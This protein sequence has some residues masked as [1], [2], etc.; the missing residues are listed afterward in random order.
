MEVGQ[1]AR[2]VENGAEA[3]GY[4]TAIA[5]D[6]VSAILS[7]VIAL[8]TLFTLRDGLRG[9]QSRNAVT[10][11]P[12]KPCGSKNRYVLHTAVAKKSN[13]APQIS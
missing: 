9:G 12:R 5:L 11:P 1:G 3:G 8:D 10:D 4:L 7:E 2:R 13:G 6:D